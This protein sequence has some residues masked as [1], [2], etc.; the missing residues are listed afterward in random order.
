MR[1]SMKSIAFQIVIALTLIPYPGL[2]FGQTLSAIPQA[3]IRLK[4]DASDLVTYGSVYR[5]GLVSGFFHLDDTLRKI[6]LEAGTSIVI[7]TTYEFGDKKIEFKVEG[8][9]DQIDT[10][11]RNVDAYLNDSGFWE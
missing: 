11:K 5:V 7:K 4:S 8:T 2:A 1:K 3:P 9:Q 10:F 6:A